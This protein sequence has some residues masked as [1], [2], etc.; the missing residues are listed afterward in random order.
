MAVYA[1]Q[2]LLESRQEFAAGVSA[3]SCSCKPR[4]CQISLLRFSFAVL[5]LFDGRSLWRFDFLLLNQPA[6]IEFRRIGF[7]AGTDHRLPAK[8]RSCPNFL[9]PHFLD[10]CRGAT[11]HSTPS[12][13]I[14]AV[15]D[16]T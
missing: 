8:S 9:E 11:G 2:F 3:R 12:S 5:C 7:V 16:V 15:A 10:S 14:C 13:L 4:P 1:P 6:D